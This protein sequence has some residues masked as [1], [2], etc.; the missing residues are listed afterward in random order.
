MLCMENDRT[1]WTGYA[2][3][4]SKSENTA[5]H[6]HDFDIISTATYQLRNYITLVSY[7]ISCDTISILLFCTFRCLYMINY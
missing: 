6:L 7:F 5:V 2:T 1:G 4:M 3:L